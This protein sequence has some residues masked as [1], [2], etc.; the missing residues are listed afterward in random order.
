MVRQW[1]VS[2]AG[3]AEVER[4]PARQS[5][6]VTTLMAPQ[7]QVFASQ[8]CPSLHI[9]AQIDT[10]VCRSTSSPERPFSIGPRQSPSPSALQRSVEPPPPADL[11][12]VQSLTADRMSPASRRP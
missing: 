8:D 3:S 2:V 1:N 6:G 12:K 7:L 4:V 5:Q 10:I 11:E 9:Q